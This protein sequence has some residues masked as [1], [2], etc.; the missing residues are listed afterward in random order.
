MADGSEAGAGPGTRDAEDEREWIPRGVTD[1]PP[2]LYARGRANGDESGPRPQPREPQRPAPFER[3]RSRLR[4][5]LGGPP[6][7]EAVSPLELRIRKAKER[8][9]ELEKRIRE[10]EERIARA[11]GG[12][13]MKMR[14]R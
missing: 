12:Q 11:L 5:A 8:G 14:S 2:Y 3:S 1:A 6:T 13:S 7:A 9:S 4:D 10:A